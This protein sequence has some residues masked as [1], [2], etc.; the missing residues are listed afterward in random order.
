M[1]PYI[2]DIRDELSKPIGSDNSNKQHAHKTKG[3]PD[4]CVQ[5]DKLCRLYLS[6]CVSSCFFW[7]LPFLPRESRTIR[8]QKIS[9]DYLEIVLRKIELL[10]Q[11][12]RISDVLMYGLLDILPLF[13][14]TNP[15][16]FEQLTSMLGEESTE[17]RHD[18]YL[19]DPILLALTYHQLMYCLSFFRALVSIQIVGVSE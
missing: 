19:V 2:W 1:E 7:P 12:C 16:L 14:Q 11:C 18:W 9:R 15:T 8:Y 13:Q 3:L 6:C 17:Q 10:L 5:D 4:L